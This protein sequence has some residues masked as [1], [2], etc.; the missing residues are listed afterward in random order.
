MKTLEEHLGDSS[1]YE[2]EKCGKSFPAF[3][4]IDVRTVEALPH[5]FV[6]SS[7]WIDHQR[8][9]A[10]PLAIADPWEAFR[11]RRSHALS[12]C[13]WTQMA[14]HPMGADLRALWAAYRQWW[15]DAPQ[16]YE[17]PSAA[18]SDAPLMPSNK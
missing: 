6:C 5:E 7:C 17:S 3:A 16:R 4:H 1:N 18:F 13:D 10:A 15:R 11:D 2:C 12:S 8:N 9:T 14:D